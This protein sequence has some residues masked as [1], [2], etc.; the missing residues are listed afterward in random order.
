[1]SSF[2]KRW[3]NLKSENTVTKLPVTDD[4]AIQEP[5]QTLPTELNNQ[6]SLDSDEDLQDSLE[7]ID[8]PI[9]GPQLADVEKLTPN[10]DFSVFM[11]KDV[12]GKVHQAAM[13]KLFTDPHFNLMDG[14]DIYIGDYSIE[15][16]LPAGMLEKMYQS[17][18][19]GLFKPSTETVEPSSLDINTADPTVSHLAE[20]TPGPVSD[21]VNMSEVKPDLI[22]H[23]EQFEFTLSHSTES[24]AIESNAIESNA[25]DLLESVKQ[26]S[27]D[28]NNIEVESKDDNT[29]L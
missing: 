15:D 10:S 28:L 22:S 8:P 18:A 21:A 20:A 27:F 3:S 2:F 24:N 7:L 17:D 6:P 4:L 23:Q 9:T 29:R 26:P 13:K 19:L 1:M 5:L 16:P 12:A 11:N 25:I 14:L